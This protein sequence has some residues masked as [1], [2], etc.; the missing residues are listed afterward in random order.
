MAF[1]EDYNE[2]TGLGLHAWI[3]VFMQGLADGPVR[4]YTFRLVMDRLE[5]AMSA[6]ERDDFSA[7][8]AS[9]ATLDSCRSQK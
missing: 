5:H 4:N 8:Q 7:R 6:E 1:C 2:Y 3:T 9:H